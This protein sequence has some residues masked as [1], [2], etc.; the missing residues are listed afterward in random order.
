M[1]GN[2]IEN[3][4]VFYKQWR[5]KMVAITDDIRNMEGL[6]KVNESDR[7]G[8]KAND[9]SGSH[10]LDVTDIVIVGDF[11]K[12][13]VLVTMSVIVGGVMMSVAAVVNGDD[14]SRGID[15]K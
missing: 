14:Q 7:W 11:E 9:S 15:E 5:R 1:N 10:L 8:E 3:V 4:L 12:I 2:K 13:G 6:T